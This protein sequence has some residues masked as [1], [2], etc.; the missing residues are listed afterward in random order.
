MAKSTPSVK[1]QKDFSPIAAMDGVRDG[2]SPTC[3]FKCDTPA[4]AKAWQKR[5]RRQL[6]DC[7]GFL[8]QKRVPLSPRTLGTVDRG[9]YVRT[10]VILRTSEHQAMPVYLLVPKNA[11]RPLPVV[12]AFHGHSYGVKDIV[13]LWED[14]AERYSP[15]GYHKDFACELAKQ[16][17]LVAAPEISC[18]GERQGDYSHLQGLEK[19][20]TPYTCHN[21]ATYATMLGKSV[22][23]LRVWDAM[24]LVDYLQTLPEADMQRLGAM[25]ISGGGMQTFFST[26][27]DPRIKACVISGYFCNWQHSIL[28][29]HHCSCNFVPGLLKLGELSDLAGLI[30]PRPCLIEAADH[31][32]I[33]PIR[34]VKQ[35]V[36]TARQAW[37]ILGADEALQADYFEG[38]HQISGAKAYDFLKQHLAK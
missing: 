1:I 7:I 31:D 32:P 15:D 29:V 23:G 38:R 27:L 35:A 25:G 36:K 19:G 16:G 21:A 2:L 24:R 12:L 34:H 5:V 22:V 33:F 8:D 14:G 9:S 3:A 4:A 30:A 37:K 18:F 28:A 17:F 10:K 6:A 20:L 13:G 26:A 11:P